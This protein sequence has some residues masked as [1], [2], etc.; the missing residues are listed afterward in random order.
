[1]TKSASLALCLALA[2]LPLAASVA[3]PAS[4]HAQRRSEAE[5]LTMEIGDQVTLPGADVASYSEGTEGIV[6]VRYDERSTNFVIAAQRA[7]V[8][9]LLLIYNDGR[10]VRYRITVSD[11]AAAVEGAGGVPIRQNIRLDMYFLQLRESYSHALGIGWPTSIG[12]GTLA[13]TLSSSIAPAADPTL[14]LTGTI[15]QALPRLDLAQSSGWGRVLRQVMLITANGEEA[16]LDT[17]GEINFQITNALNV[18]IRTIRYGSVLTVTPRFDSATRRIDLAVSA[19]VS[20]ITAPFQ[21][22]GPPGRTRTTVSTL[23]NLELGESIV[24]G[25]AVAN[26]TNESQGGLAGLS[27]IP[28]LGALFGTNVRAAENTENYLFIVPTVV[29]AVSRSESD[30]I[31]E[32]LELYRNFGTIGGRGLADIE[33]FEP[34]PPGHE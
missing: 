10:Q 22:D 17:G 7:G 27:Q 13:F 14:N 20:E 30:R 9:S 8:T 2:A 3:A 4:V 19:D 32:V 23:V 33:L 25:G 29:E 21:P 12:G 1:M 6:S 16:T 24:L 26:T 28:I 5:T 34:T 18:E 31:G 15:N 11:A